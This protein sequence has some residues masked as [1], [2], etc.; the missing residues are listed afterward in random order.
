MNLKVRYR[1][2]LTETVQQLRR[3]QPMHP[4]KMAPQKGHGGIWKTIFTKAFEETQPKNKEELNELIDHCN[5]AKNMMSRENMAIVLCSMC[6][7]AI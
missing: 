1:L 2:V 6:L 5:N 4:G 7:D 3:L